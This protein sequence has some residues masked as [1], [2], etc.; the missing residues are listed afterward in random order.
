MIQMVTVLV[1][2]QQQPSEQFVTKTA[3]ILV[4]LFDSNKA[5]ANTWTQ[6][7]VTA[8][9]ATRGRLNLVQFVELVDDF[10]Q[11]V[12]ELLLHE[13]PAA[14]V[15]GCLPDAIVAE[16]AT[17]GLQGAIDQII[18]ELDNG[19]YNVKA[20]RT[21]SPW[22]DHENLKCLLKYKRNH[23]NNWEDWQEVATRCR[24]VLSEIQ[25]RNKW[26]NLLKT[27]NH[28]VKVCRQSYLNE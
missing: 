12:S 23:P 24:P 10:K 9:C 5:E 14:K 27:N 28:I 18:N 8:L 21:T 2:N 25:V 3:A 17:T 16:E 6:K 19:T 15:S 11:Y 4:G 1:K 13:G 26:Y 22:N 20:S 7:E